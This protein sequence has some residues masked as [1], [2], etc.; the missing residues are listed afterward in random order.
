MYRGMAMIADI[1]LLQKQPIFE[2]EIR[3][4]SLN[5]SL[6]VLIKKSVYKLSFK[7]KVSVEQR[8]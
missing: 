1:F 6:L 8:A 2:K 5:L 7:N 3:T 4:V